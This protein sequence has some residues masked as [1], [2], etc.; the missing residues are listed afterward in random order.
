MQ[1]RDHPLRA[2]AVDLLRTLN[3]QH[4]TRETLRRHLTVSVNEAGLLLE[5]LVAGGV[6]RKDGMSRYAVVPDAPVPPSNAAPEQAPA[7]AA[8]G[9]DGPRASELSAPTASAASSNGESNST[10]RVQPG[11][12]QEVCFVQNRPR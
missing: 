7:V 11:C 2:A 3:R 12:D 1:N 10:S 4:V 5:Q 9:L 6:L 8:P